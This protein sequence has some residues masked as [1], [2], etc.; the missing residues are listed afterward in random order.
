[1]LL[2]INYRTHTSLILTLFV[3]MLH[4]THTDLCSGVTRQGGAGGRGK[5]ERPPP[6]PPKKKKTTKKNTPKN[7]SVIEDS[8]SGEKVVFFLS[9]LIPAGKSNVVYKT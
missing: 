7:T 3:V 5:K 8:L 4:V 9:F 6:P 1:M 2:L